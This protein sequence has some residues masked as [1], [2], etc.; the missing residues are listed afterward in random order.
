MAVDGTYNVQWSSEMGTSAGTITLKVDGNS[1]SGS[2]SSDQGTY[3]FEEGKVSGDE[4]EWSMQVN[5]PQ[6]GELKVD[7]KGTV[8][9]DDI[10]GQVQHDIPAAYFQYR[11]NLVYYLLL[12]LHVKLTQIDFRI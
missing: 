5:A 1:L 8:S 2:L 6:I 4:F 11:G 7:V 12:L 10:S 3:Q 9:G